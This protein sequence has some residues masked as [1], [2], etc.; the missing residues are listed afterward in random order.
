MIQRVQ[1]SADVRLIECVNPV[2]QKWRIRFDLQVRDENT[3][4]YLEAEF[5]YRPTRD[6]IR[7]TITAHYNDQVEQQILSGFE[8]EGN[9]VWLSAENQFNYKAAHDLAFQTQGA[10]LPVTFKFGTDDAPVYRTF[11]TLSDLSDF[12]RR[13]L[14]HIQDALRAGWKKKD[15]IDMSLYHL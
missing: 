13:A 15:E 4:D 2:R 1:G 12:H 5:D 6:E 8:Y 11:D 3:A 9:A 7:A 10:T 14:Q